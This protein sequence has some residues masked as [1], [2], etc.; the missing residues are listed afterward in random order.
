MHSIKLYTSFVPA[1]QLKAG[2]LQ[3]VSS[4]AKDRVPKDRTGGR[5]PRA[6]CLLLGAEVPVSWKT[7]MIL[8]T[9]IF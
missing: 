3:L 9:R 4:F 7:E 5:S 2:P 6:Q 8:I 1:I